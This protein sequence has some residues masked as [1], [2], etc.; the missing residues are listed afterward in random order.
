MATIITITLFTSNDTSRE[1]ANRLAA[2]VAA[3]ESRASIEANVYAEAKVEY[4]EQADVMAL[5]AL[6]AP[7][8][9]EAA[10]PKPKRQRKA[11]Q[12]SPSKPARSPRSRAATK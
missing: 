6:N 11:K 10:A 9:D 12:P 8:E 4:V 2:D 3:D 5:A 7:T 1:R